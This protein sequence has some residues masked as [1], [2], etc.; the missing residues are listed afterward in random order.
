MLP[1]P[2]EDTSPLECF[3]ALLVGRV[4]VSQGFMRG[5]FV[6]VLILGLFCFNFIFVFILSVKKI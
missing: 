4:V 1:C 3:F 5:F 6:V 2:L